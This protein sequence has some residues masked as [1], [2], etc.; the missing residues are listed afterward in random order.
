MFEGSNIN[1]I[2]IKNMDYIGLNNYLSIEFTVS[3]NSKKLFV[4]TNGEYIIPFSG[5][6]FNK[7]YKNIYNSTNHI[8]INNGIVIYH[9]NSNTNKYIDL[10]INFWCPSCNK[11]MIDIN[12]FISKKPNINIRL[13][14]IPLN[15]NQTIAI[16]IYHSV[17]KMNLDKSLKQS[18]LNWLTNN[19]I[20]S[21]KDKN[22]VLIK[23]IEHA[24]NN[25]IKN[26]LKTRTLSDTSLANDLILFERLNIQNIPFI[27]F[28]KEIYVGYDQCFKFI[29]EGAFNEQE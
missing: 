2:N 15:D 12:D 26:E 29:K 8:N 27:I 19:D 24:N 4:L 3:D 14:I 25:K 20:D 6:I 1:I 23:F 13:H 21:F 7:T 22:N 18:Y 11:L 16:Q 28:N 5:E 17:Y 10:F 9:C